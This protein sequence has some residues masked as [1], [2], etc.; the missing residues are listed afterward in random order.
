[1]IIR[2]IIVIVGVGVTYWMMNRIADVILS[3]E[4]FLRIDLLALGIEMALINLYRVVRLMLQ[5]IIIMGLM[6]EGSLI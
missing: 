5:L 4:T 3:I 1:M 6:V 2:V